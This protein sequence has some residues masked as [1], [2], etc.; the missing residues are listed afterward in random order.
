M[1]FVNGIDEKR[2]KDYLME[3]G[4]YDQVKQS[5]IDYVFGKNYPA[6]DGFLFII[7]ANNE[8]EKRNENLKLKEN[9]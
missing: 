8:W 9:K 2:A 3:L 4:I 1:E 7:A 5:A 6:N